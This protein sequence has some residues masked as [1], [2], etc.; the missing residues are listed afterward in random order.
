MLH[1]ASY[2]LAQQLVRSVHNVFCLLAYKLIN[3]ITRPQDTYAISTSRM[4]GFT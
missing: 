1:F 2:F 4:L 3:E